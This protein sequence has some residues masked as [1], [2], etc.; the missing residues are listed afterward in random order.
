MNTF[1][2]VLTC[3]TDVSGMLGGLASLV[4]L[5]ASLR[6]W[7]RKRCKRRRGR[8]AGNG[9]LSAGPDQSQD[10]HQPGGLIDPEFHEPEVT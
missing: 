6:K 5:Y 1:M 2:T 10:T 8:A 3:A 9:A 7:T 4:V